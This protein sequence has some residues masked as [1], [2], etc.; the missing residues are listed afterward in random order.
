MQ[1]KKLNPWKRISS[2]IVYENPWFKIREDQVEK[3]GNRTGI[4]G[5]VEIPP[6]VLIVPIN[7]QNETYL[8]GLYRYPTN[9]YSIEIPAGNTEGQEPLEAAKR[10]LLE[11]TGLVAGDWKKI[12]EVTPYD[13]ISVEVDHV[14]LAT[15]LEQTG[16]PLDQKEGILEVRRIPFEKAFDLIKSGEISNGQTI[17]ALSL[18]KIYLEK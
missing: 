1:S 6:S 5:L 16:Q 14:Y 11:E 8:I 10:E 2:K 18:A 17:T 7:E 15:N 3:P 12:G 9:K 13:G 4:Y